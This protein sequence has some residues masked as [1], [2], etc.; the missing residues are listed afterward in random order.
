MPFSYIIP[1]TEI[2][3]ITIK[4]QL[5][6]LVTSNIEHYQSKPIITAT[7]VRDLVPGIENISDYCGK[8]LFNCPY[9]DGW[10]MRDKPLAVII[11]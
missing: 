11:E 4:D 1:K 9:C 5:F 10:E 2:I 7:G 8:S 6:V 3:S